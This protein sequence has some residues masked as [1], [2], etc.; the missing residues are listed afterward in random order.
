MIDCYLRLAGAQTFL[1]MGG[2][3]AP[4]LLIHGGGLGSTGLVWR[5]IVPQLEARHRLLIPDL[6]GYGHSSAAQAP[7][8]ISG[9]AK[10]MEALLD[11]F[12]LERITVIGHSMGCLVALALTALNP[13]R[14]AGLGLIA[15]G[16]RV[17][18]I[19][20]YHSAGH[21]V[22]RAAIDAPGPQT[23][24]RVVEI[25]NANLDDAPAQIEERLA[26]ASDP[27][28]IKAQRAGAQARNGSPFTFDWSIYAGPIL[29][30]WGEE[31]RFNP[32]ELGDQIAAGLPARRVYRR[33]KAGH[34]V[35][36]DAPDDLAQ[37]FL[38]FSQACMKQPS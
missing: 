27:A 8:G 29:F 5:D 30:G 36:H 37:A 38:S 6:M 34:N 18:D 1:R 10:Q 22:M 19:T 21:E 13:D 14:I 23:M 20:G 12:C 35:P 24:R 9:L 33:F 7:G 25:L 2:D 32:P 3:G 17:A 26:F 11:V 16:G 15:P 31:E 4:I 28:H